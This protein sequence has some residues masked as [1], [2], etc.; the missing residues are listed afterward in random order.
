MMSKYA[1]ANVRSCVCAGLH[2]RN[3]LSSLPPSLF[4]LP[5]LRVLIVSNNKLCS[6][7]ASIYALAHLRQL[8]R[9]GRVRAPD[10]HGCG[11]LAVSAGLG[12][13]RPWGHAWPG[14]LFNRAA[15]SVPQK[16]NSED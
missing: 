13:L 1:H 8:V 16:P 4:Q 2:S 6:L 11:S 15:E 5:F 3:L 12:K 7:S 10:R 9:H 14:E